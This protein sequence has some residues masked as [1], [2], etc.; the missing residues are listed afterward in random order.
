MSQHWKTFVQQPVFALMLTPCRCWNKKHQETK[1]LRPPSKNPHD[2]IQ[3]SKINDASHRK[4]CLAGAGLGYVPRMKRKNCVSK[5]PWRRFRSAWSVLCPVPLAHVAAGEGKGRVG[6][7]G[8]MAKV[9][10]LLS[11]T[12]QGKMR[13]CWILSWFWVIAASAHFVVTGR[14]WDNEPVK[15]VVCKSKWILNLYSNDRGC[16]WKN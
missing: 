3:T 9:G 16:F 7:F 13:D 10:G 1:T 14:W 8:K 2:F 6:W 15:D 5:R 12:C 11:L 4:S